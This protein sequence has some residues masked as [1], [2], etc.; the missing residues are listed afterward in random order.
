MSVDL[1]YLEKLSK[2]RIEDDKRKDQSHD[3]DI[4]NCKQLSVH[5]S[6]S[7]PCFTVFRQF[8]SEFSLPYYDMPVQ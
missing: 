1:E 6:P 5:Y 3:A 7:F 2:L 4:Q 8:L